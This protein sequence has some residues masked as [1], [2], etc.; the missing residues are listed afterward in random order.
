MANAQEL[1]TNGGFETGTSI[2]WDFSQQGDSTQ[3]VVSNPGYPGLGSSPTNNFYAFAG[4][5]GGLS[6]N[7]FRQTFAVPT[8]ITALQFSFDYAYRNFATSFVNP[9]PD[10]LAFN[11]GGVN[12]QQF[13]V[14]ILTGAAAF[15]TVNPADIVFSAIQTTPSSSLVQPWISFSQDIFGA[16][17]SF[18]GQNLQVRFAEVD[19]QDI[20]DIGFDNVS[21]MATATAIPDPSSSLAALLLGLGLVSLWFSRKLECGSQPCGQ[22]CLA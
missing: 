2:G 16:V 14:E 15:D 7:I 6:Q 19:N 10:T 5:Q 9:S 4:D 1:I 12:N 22:A 11:A 17:S 3:S 8:G 21:L 18:Q 13:R 20:F